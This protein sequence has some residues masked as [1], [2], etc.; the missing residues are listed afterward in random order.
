MRVRQVIDGTSGLVSGA[1]AERMAGSG[2]LL[3]G[4]VSQWQPEQGIFQWFN[5]P[6]A[7]EDVITWCAAAPSIPLYLA[8]F[9]VLVLFASLLPSA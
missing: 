6:K 7:H 5:L 3:A 9:C 4:T 1:V 2:L 8:V